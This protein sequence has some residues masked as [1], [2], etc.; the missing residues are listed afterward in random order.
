MLTG[1]EENVSLA[2][3]SKLPEPVWSEE[4]AG[5]AVET[6]S[7][8]AAVALGSPC[9]VGGLIKVSKQLLASASPG[10]DQLLS[11]DLARACSRQ[12]DR[13]CFYGTGTAN[14]PRGILSTVGIHLINVSTDDPGT[15]HFLN[16]ERLIENEDCGPNSAFVTSPDL[17]AD[18]RRRPLWVGGSGQTLWDYL[19]NPVASPAITGEHIFF[20][21]I[22][23]FLSVT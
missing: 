15:E 9:R 21:M 17:K 14:M 18:L 1:L 4:N 5:F 20:A 12:L 23:P 11:D 16:A 22:S 6:D 13:I 8:F 3:V 7:E 10:L 2:H 19:T